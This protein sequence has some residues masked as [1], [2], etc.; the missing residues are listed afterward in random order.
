MTNF[1]KIYLFE[2]GKTETGY[3]ISNVEFRLEEDE[4][5][6]SAY[7]SAATDTLTCPSWCEGKK[8]KIDTPKG[9]IIKFYCKTSND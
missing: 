8:E 6:C 1:S 9:Q 3:K 2:Q 4:Q 7:Y 5:G